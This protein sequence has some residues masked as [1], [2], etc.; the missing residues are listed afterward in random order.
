MLNKKITTT[1]Q[2]AMYGWHSGHR[3]L[4]VSE[5]QTKKQH[6]HYSLHFVSWIK[7]NFF[8]LFLNE[9]LTEL[10]IFHFIYVWFS[11]LKWNI[12]LSAVDYLVILGMQRLDGSP[13]TN[14]LLN[15]VERQFLIHRS[16]HRS[17]F[18]MCEYTR[19]IRK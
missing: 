9:F 3:D 15:L 13:M 16:F 10:L 1:T 4:L 14:L 11:L 2:P 7:T 19:K 12:H 6:T 8:E 18:S 5:N 17:Q